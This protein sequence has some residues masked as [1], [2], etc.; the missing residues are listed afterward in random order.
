MIAI[1]LDEE[2][3]EEVQEKQEV[4]NKPVWV[5]QL[6][7]DKELLGEFHTIYSKLTRNL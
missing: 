6:W 2:E 3:M 1:A 7:L 4:I 5:S